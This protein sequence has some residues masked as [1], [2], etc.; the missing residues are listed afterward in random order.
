MTPEIAFECLL[1]SHD[2]LLL[3]TLDKILRDFSISSNLCL[4]PSQASHWLAKKH[5]DLVVIDWDEESSSELLEEI[6]M[7]PNQRKPTIMAI[8]ASD[9]SI[10]GVH[11]VLRRPVTAETGRESLKLAYSRMLLDHRCHARF[12]LMKSVMA[13]DQNERSIPVTII[14]IGDSGVGISTLERLAA[15]DELSFRLMLPGVE[16]EIHIQ[17]RVIW[18]RE[19]GR[20]GCE[21]VRIPPVDLNILRDWLRQSVRVKKPLIPV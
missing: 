9:S 1:I 21:F 7:S 15:G 14:D 18:T 4:S 5:A 11:I 13:T 16:R 6:W 2:A 3:R 8:S 10:P 19:W 12:T 17:A 20:A